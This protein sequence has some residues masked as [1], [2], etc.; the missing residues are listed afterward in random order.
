M[1]R[2]SEERPCTGAFPPCFHHLLFN[3]F[4]SLPAWQLFTI[5]LTTSSNGDSCLFALSIHSLFSS[6]HFNCRKSKKNPLKNQR[7][8]L[9]SVRRFNREC[10]TAAQP[11]MSGGQLMTLGRARF[12]TTSLWLLTAASLMLSCTSKVVSVSSEL[13]RSFEIWQVLVSS[14][15]LSFRLDF[16]IFHFYGQFLS[17]TKFSP[18]FLW[19]APRWETAPINSG[20]VLILL[21]AD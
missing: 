19:F 2:L 21:S 13:L 12:L 10:P 15:T 16:H 8:P 6:F 20:S 11:R 4:P 17:S 5:C 1:L 18:V 7:K 3:S 14:T 9:E